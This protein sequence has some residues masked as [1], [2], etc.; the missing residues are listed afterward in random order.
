MTTYYMGLDAGS[1]YM[2]AVLIAEDQVV[3][4]KLLP[5]GI[6]CEKTAAE[7]VQA[8]KRDAAITC[9]LYTSDAA[10]EL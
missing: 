6:D 9:L 4:T 5:T 1:T 8:I 10:D 2:K 3:S 7:L